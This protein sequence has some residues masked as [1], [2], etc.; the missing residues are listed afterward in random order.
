MSVALF[1]AL[2]IAFSLSVYR[3]RWQLRRRSSSQGSQAGA[4]LYDA[5]FRERPTAATAT[6]S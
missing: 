5:S 6:R 3:R 4:E 2:G 1:I